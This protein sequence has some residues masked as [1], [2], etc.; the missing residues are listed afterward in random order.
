MLLHL[1]KCPIKSSVLFCSLDCWLDA[2]WCQEATWLKYRKSPKIYFH[3]GNSLHALSSPKVDSQWIL[4][5]FCES[6]STA[7]IQCAT[8][9]KQLLIRCLQLT[10]LLIWRFNNRNKQKESMVGINS[11]RQKDLYSQSPVIRYGNEWSVCVFYTFKHLLFPP[12]LPLLRV[13]TV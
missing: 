3:R 8:Q 1:Y 9:K 7:G 10:H 5:D 4:G 2:V 11:R 13:F 12:L 6:N